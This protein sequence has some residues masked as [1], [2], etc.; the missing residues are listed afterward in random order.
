LELELSKLNRKVIS[1]FDDWFI[2][3]DR[4]VVEK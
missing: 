3:V 1:W 2:E 4:E